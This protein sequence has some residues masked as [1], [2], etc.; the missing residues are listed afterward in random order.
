VAP[1]QPCAAE[2]LVP[3]DYMTLSC[4]SRRVRLARG[5]GEG[6]QRCSVQ[7][8]R[9]HSGCNRLCQ[10][11]QLGTQQPHTC[12]CHSSSGDALMIGQLGGFGAPPAGAAATLGEGPTGL[13]DG[14]GR[15]LAVHF[16]GFPA[17]DKC[18]WDSAQEANFPA[19]AT[20]LG[21]C[22]PAGVAGATPWELLWMVQAWPTGLS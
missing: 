12:R 19:A 22:F 4:T 15:P 7:H 21:S 5:E 11:R 13:L 16:L 1:T 20:K 17:A 2:G 8:S 14:K 9:Q 10:W 3:Q 18:W 6:S